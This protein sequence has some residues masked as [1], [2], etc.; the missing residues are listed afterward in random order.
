MNER[1]DTSK[2][3]FAVKVG[4]AEMLK[5][6]ARPISAATAVWHACRILT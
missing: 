4:L 5:V 2:D 3:N 1:P 6:G